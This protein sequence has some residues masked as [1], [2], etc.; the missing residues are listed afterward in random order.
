MKCP[1][2]NKYCNP[3]ICFKTIKHNY[4]CSG[5]SS[6]PTKYKKDIVWLCLKGK[7]SQ[8]QLELTKGEA[9]GIISVLTG[10]LFVEETLRNEIN[11]RK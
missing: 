5:I 9:L 2:K 10:S 6:K 4:I 11:N 8:T 1:K 7:F 3:S